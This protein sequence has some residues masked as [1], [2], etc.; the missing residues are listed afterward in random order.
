[1]TKVK[2]GF[3]FNFKFLKSNQDDPHS[4]TSAWGYF[5]IMLSVKVNIL[6]NSYEF[7]SAPSLTVGA[8]AK[9][10]AKNNIL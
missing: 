5:F 2:L 1:M 10:S 3:L 4:K 8:T 9:G 7:F 6:S